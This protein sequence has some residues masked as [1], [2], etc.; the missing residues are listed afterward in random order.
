M[1][2]TLTEGLRDYVFN[3]RA[4]EAMTLWE[5]A[6]LLKELIP[7]ADIRVPRGEEKGGPQE[8]DRRAQEQLGYVP[9]YSARRGFQEYISFLKSGRYEKVP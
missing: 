7:A 1:L 2:A 3:I 8:V 6:V 9:E 4:K 5:V